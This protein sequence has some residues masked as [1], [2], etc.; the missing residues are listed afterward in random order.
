M[1]TDREL[2]E[3]IAADSAATR[4]QILA[5]LTMVAKMQ[6]QV[7]PMLESL[8]KSPLLKMFVR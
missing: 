1:S 3:Q 5:I 8:S 4:A 7:A 6:D 2:L